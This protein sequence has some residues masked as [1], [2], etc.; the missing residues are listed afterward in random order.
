[1]KY[2]RM[3][4]VFLILALLLGMMPAA[5]AATSRCDVLGHD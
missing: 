1:M 4:A 2:R 5:L 3:I